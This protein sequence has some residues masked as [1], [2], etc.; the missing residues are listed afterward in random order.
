MSVSPRAVAVRGRRRVGRGGSGWIGALPSN[1]LVGRGGTRRLA[2][3][4]DWSAP[5]RRRWRRWRECLPPPPRTLWLTAS[6]QDVTCVAGGTPLRPT[7]P[8]P[9][10]RP[11]LWVTIASCP[12]PRLSVYP[13]RGP[14]PVYCFFS[15]CVMVVPTASPPVT[16]GL[17][18]VE[19]GVGVNRGGWWTSGGE[20]A[21]SSLPKCPPRSR[22]GTQAARCHG[23][24]PHR[25]SPHTPIHPVRRTGVAV[26]SSPPPTTV[27][28]ALLYSS[29]AR[30]NLSPFS[31]FLFR[32]SPC[33]A[34]SHP[35]CSF[36]SSPPTDSA[37]GTVVGRRVCVVAQSESAQRRP[38]PSPACPVPAGW[39]RQDTP[40]PPGA[41]VCAGRPRVFAGG[42]RR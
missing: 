4:D 28:P 22:W 11:S 8:P 40:R 29:P 1:P 39:L 7:P 18:A 37:R 41:T 16:H 5:P 20:N 3:D 24:P 31:S 21:C 30:H 34:R 26:P 14:P 19:R 6:G 25:P 42:R 12:A 36:W 27:P 9:P 10:P 13:P 33:R 2:V 35:V 38:R 23:R 15:A 32:P 17:D